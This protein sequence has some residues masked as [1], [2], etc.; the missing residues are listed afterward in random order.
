MRNPILLVVVLLFIS[1]I[2]SALPN[3]YLRETAL[4]ET[5]TVNSSLASAQ[6]S[7]A[8]VAL[9]NQCKGTNWTKKDNWLIGRLDTWQG[10]TVE[11][12]RVVELDLGDQNTS[13][14]LTGTIPLELSNLNEIRVINLGNNK[15]T[16]NLPES[17]S[18]LS[19][20]TILNLYN[21][22]LSGILPISWSA[23]SNLQ[24]LILS[25]NKFSGNLPQDWASL[26]NLSQLLLS[27]NQLIGPLPQGWSSLVNLNYLQLSG[28][29]LSG[30]LPDSW[31]ALEKLFQLGIGSNQITGALPD[32]WSVLDNLHELILS[33]NNLTGTLPDSWAALKN[34]TQL[35]LNDN[36][37][38]GTLPDS[39]SVLANL[40]DLFLS[41][42]QLNGSLP[43]SWSKLVN[44]K[45]LNL[46]NNLLTGTLPD[47]WTT[48]INLYSLYLSNN[49]FTGIFPDSYK[50]LENMQNLTL[51]DNQLS[52][53]PKLTGFSQLNLLIAENNLF[54]FGDIE[55]NV[56]IP[57]LTYSYSPQSPI[58]QS[59][60]ITK[61]LGEECRIS[62]SVGGQSNIYQW[63]KNG[64][65]ISGANQ[66]EYVIPS[67]TLTDAGL[68]TCQ[69]TNSVA[70]QLTLVSN[71]KTLQIGI[72]TPSTSLDSLALVALYNQCNGVNW[73]KQDNWLIG[74][75]STWQGVTVENGRVV[76][77]NLRDQDNSVG[78]TGQLPN[79]LSN[80]TM[81]RSID[82]GWNNLSGT[83]PESW[84]AFVNLQQLWLPNNQFTGS[85]PSS[86]SSLVNLTDLNLVYNEISGSLPAGWS[87][88]VNL[89][90]LQL[91]ENKL[92][93]TLPVEWSSL[94]NL[95][96]LGLTN[97]Q[98][99]GSLPSEWSSLV[100]LVSLQL[101]EDK[102]TGTLPESWSSMIKL[103]QLNLGSNQLPGN[104]RTGITGTLPESWSALVELNDLNLS[105]NR[106][107]GIVPESWKALIKLKYLTLSNNRI[108]GLPNLASFSN[109]EYLIVE[110]NLLDFGDI[111][112]NIGIPKM[113][114]AYDFQGLIGESDSIILYTGDEFKISVEVGGSSNQYQWFKN[115]IIIP[116]ETGSEY[117]ITSVSSNDEGNYNCKITNTVATQLTLTSRLITLQIG[118]TP[119]VINLDSLALVALYNQCNGPNWTRKD[120][121]LV[122]RLATWQGVTVEYGRVTF[123]DLHDPNNSV[124]LVGPLPA[125]L[126]NLT[127]IRC[128]LLSNN[129]LSGNLPESWAAFVN[130]EL[131]MLD[132]NQFTGVLPD[133]WSGMKNIYG[134]GLD[135]N[136]LSG[137]LPQSWSVLQN[138]E[139]ICLSHNQFT[140]L[141]PESWSALIKLK[142]LFLNSNKLTG[143]LPVNWSSL[144]RL[145]VLWLFENQL[146]GN[147]PDEW[148]AFRNMASIDFSNNKLS[149]NLPDSWSS[150]TKLISL[151]LNLNQFNGMLPD[152]WSSFVN[153]IE[154]HLDHNQLAGSFPESWK[155]IT[156][157]GYLY[158]NNNQISVLPLLSDFSMLNVLTVENN[159][160]D[161]GDIEPN[162]SIP[163]TIYTY[164]PQAK[165]GEVDTIIKNTGTEFRT[166]VT[167]GGTSNQYQWY[168]DEVII[169]GATSPEYII[170][171][172]SLTDEG[173]YNCL[174]TNTVA[175]QLT[176]ESNPITLQVKDD[177]IFVDAGRDQFVYERCIVSLDASAS[178]D[179]NKKPLKFKWTAP[180]EI[181]LSSLADA[182]PSFRAPDVAEPQSYTFSLVVNDGVRDSPMDQVT[183]TVLDMIRVYPNI[184]TGI[185]NIEFNAG[186]GHET[187]ILVT[188]LIG[189]ELL[190]KK[191]LNPSLFQLDLSIFADETYIILI[192]Y[193]TK[194]YTSKVILRKA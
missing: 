112:P 37:F 118:I 126:S 10:V 98:I 25:T 175:T 161:F 99:S 120:N 132:K 144:E 58:G 35:L 101:W 146:T 30:T 54:D 167:V 81:I 88:L 97:N 85:L 66:T 5:S 119:P 46:S 116:G 159:L 50:A 187:E 77:L 109:L 43:E 80:L 70:T 151:T 100:N 140:G 124:G 84:S 44:L 186:S 7:L 155:A 34:L 133:S 62:V 182:K 184:T 71:P 92:S 104:Q 19:N 4:S 121:W 142:S 123:L 47:S 131:L 59:E 152:S 170:P 28:N 143:T 39:W 65:L 191:I 165:I 110:R 145:E 90:Y 75:L 6:D 171:S 192:K 111:E 163:Q 94:V 95:Y 29:K 134:F 177:Q 73:T 9:Y 13:V 147:L 74:R 57:K 154:L 172:V 83:L 17:W 179:L 22:Q 26:I 86:W 45:Q 139:D 61:N 174:I 125:E 113:I 93:G 178:I 188:N 193:D 183:V 160:L 128:L 3:N 136:Y 68:Y 102:I 114:Y 185:V 56:D 169:A 36:K 42:N 18:G 52:D 162:I 135:Y 69:I 15:L 106:L 189:S 153:L 32:S 176:L 76:A 51:N 38:S 33:E 87:T 105:G 23:L 31:A 157:L 82:L 149:G 27:N 2:I 21:N 96:I 137:E 181:I 67:V 150:M 130:L 49:Q 138:L 168:K 20:L 48:L 1:K 173:N 60:T 79:E 117:I 107:S 72:N 64:I 190:R 8:L 41:G 108:T 24:V 127:A 166:S 11:N 129:Q 53:L 122:G 158:L 40:N 156:N 14:G 103:Q 55:P 180:S 164:S 194:H 91:D 16:G 141:L 63:Y 78:L 115:T 12:G 89:S 148:K